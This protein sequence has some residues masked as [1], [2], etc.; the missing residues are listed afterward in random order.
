MSNK[1]ET[2][3]VV[4]NYLTS[5]LL[6]I[7]NLFSVM[8][9]WYVNKSIAWAIFHWFFGLFYLIYSILDR[10]FT[11]GGLMEIINYYF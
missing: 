2:V 3:V 5:P 4:K 1:K 7:I 10:K 6:L 9:S 11:D 8:V